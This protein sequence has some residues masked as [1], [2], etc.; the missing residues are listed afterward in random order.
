A[1]LSR[2]KAGDRERDSSLRALPLH[3]VEV[4][5][6]TGVIAEDERAPWPKR[7]TPARLEPVEITEIERHAHALRGDG[8]LVDEPVAANFIYRHVTQNARE[9]RRGLFPW[10]PAVTE[11]NRRRIGEAQQRGHRIKMVLSMNDVRRRRGS[12]EGGNQPDC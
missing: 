10:Q 12:G 5:V 11:I 8:A 4:G 3:V 2:L 1:D 7:Q 6:F 9:M